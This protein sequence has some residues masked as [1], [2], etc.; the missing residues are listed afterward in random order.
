MK[1]S[2]IYLAGGCFWGVEHFMSLIRG[3][4]CT[5]AG[6]ANGT[7]ENPSYSDVCNNNTGHAETVHVIY[8]ENTISLEK[9]LSLFFKIIDPS[10]LNRQGNDTGVQYRTGIYYTRADDLPVIEKMINQLST[11]C[12]KPVVVEISELKN[13]YS[14]EDYHQKYLRKNP[15][16][17]CHIN[18]EL[19]E[20]ARNTQDKQ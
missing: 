6:Y 19:F 7:T 13:F 16:G 20:L 12:T 11:D 1:K 4:V 17:Y 15:S 18:P 10:S 2:E 9:I 14:A 8:D 3:I 5:E